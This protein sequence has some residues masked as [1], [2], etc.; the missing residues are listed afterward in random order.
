MKARDPETAD[1]WQEA[2]DIAEFWLLIDSAR[3]YGLVKGANR[4]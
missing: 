2:V 4:L 3:Q 1:E